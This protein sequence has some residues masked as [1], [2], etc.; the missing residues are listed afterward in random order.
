MVHLQ[1]NLA[2]LSITLNA[3]EMREINEI[4]TLDSVAGDRYAHMAMT[5]HGNK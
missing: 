4:F 3:E 2:A 5:F 1:E